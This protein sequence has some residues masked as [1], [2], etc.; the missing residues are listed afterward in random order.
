MTATS[1]DF[2]QKT[3][4][5]LLA[6]LVKQITAGAMGTPFV[7]AGAMARDLLLVHAHG[8]AS[9]RAT[10]DVDLAFL[11]SGWDEFEKLRQRLLDGEFKEIPREGIHKLR[12][13]G[14][15]EVDILPFGGVERPDRT[16][17]LPPDNDFSMSMFGFSEALN[18]AVTVFLP[19]AASVHVVSLPALAILKLSAWTERRLT[20]PGKDA[21]DLRLIVKNYADIAGERLY[22]ANPY[23]V[24][25]PSDYEGAGAWLLGK[26][27]ARLLDSNGRERLA[28]LIADEADEAGQLRL[29]GDM[30]HDDPERALTLLQALE[31]GFVEQG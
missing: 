15:L 16:I 30:M 22:E 17:V 23:V 29:A 4:L 24:G 7:L 10:E 13:R 31:E 8:V 12:F 20:E 2:S 28:R 27:M 14:S 26:D 5:R 21:Y 11:V 18:S 3:D 25:S 6:A 1:L 9:N 19:D